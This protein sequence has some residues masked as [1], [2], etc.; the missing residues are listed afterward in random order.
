MVTNVA[1]PVAKTSGTEGQSVAPISLTVI[2]GL[3]GLSTASAVLKVCSAIITTAMVPTMSY[4]SNRTVSVMTSA[5]PYL[6][7]ITVVNTSNYVT[8]YPVKETVNKSNVDQVVEDKISTV[9]SERNKLT[10]QI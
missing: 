9:A 5:G 7:I 8:G 4:A 6:P 2:T 3:D 1:S 10:D